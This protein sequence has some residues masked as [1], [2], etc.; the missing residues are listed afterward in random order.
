MKKIA[1][2]N[3][4]IIGCGHLGALVAT[5]LSNAGGTVTVIDRDKN[6]FAKL[7]PSFGGLTI[8]GNATDIDVLAE[9]GI[10]PKTTVVCATNHGNTNIMAAQMAKVLFSA[11]RVI[12]RLYNPEKAFVYEEEGVET[13]CPDDLAA[14][15]IFDRINEGL[16]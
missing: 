10:S 3:I 15:E 5:S 14:Q 4:V 11:K 2:G 8:V 9:A 7:S 13:I 1:Q 12:A 6:S 16:A